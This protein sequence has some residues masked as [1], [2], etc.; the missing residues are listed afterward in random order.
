MLSLPR[1]HLVNMHS[2]T[3]SM[4]HKLSCYARPVGNAHEP[5]GQSGRHVLLT[6]HEHIGGLQDLL[7]S[8]R[9]DW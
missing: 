9:N 2:P 3:Q 6:P 7:K 8:R 1:A 5:G 4:F